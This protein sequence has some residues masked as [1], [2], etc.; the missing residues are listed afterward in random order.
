MKQ[1]SLLLLFHFIAITV[2]AQRPD[3]VQVN[4]QWYFVYPL[5]EKVVPNEAI[6][7]QLDLSE[8]QFKL[9]KEWKLTNDTRLK[10]FKRTMTDSLNR[11]LI[12]TKI[13]VPKEQ[14][15]YEW[16]D[17]TQAPKLSWPILLMRKK[18][19]Y[20]K[21]P[22]LMLDRDLNQ[23]QDLV[24][25]VQNLPNGKYIQYFEPMLSYHNRK[26]SSELPTRIAAMFELKNNLPENEFTRFNYKGDTIRHGF[27]TD[28]LKE[29]EWTLSNR[30][31]QFHSGIHGLNE[32]RTLY[33]YG[34]S[35][36]VELKKGILE[37]PFYERIGGSYK[38]V[39]YFKN[40]YADSIWRIE[41]YYAWRTNEVIDYNSVL[42]SNYKQT[43]SLIMEPSTRIYKKYEGFDFKERRDS[44]NSIPYQNCQED[45]YEQ[46]VPALPVMDFNDLFEKPMRTGLVNLKLADDNRT[47]YQRNTGHVNFHGTK[48]IFE[49]TRLVERYTYVPDLG[50]IVFTRFYK[51]GGVFDTLG[52]EAQSKLFV[53]NIYDANGKLFRTTTYN[54]AGEQVQQ[55]DYFKRKEKKVHYEKPVMIEGFETVLTYNFGKKIRQWDSYLVINGKAY[56]KI[57]WTARSKKRRTE[58]YEDLRDSS[59]HYVVYNRKGD[60]AMEQVSYLKAID[61]S[62][63][64][65]KAIYGRRNI[66]PYKGIKLV[67]ENEYDTD[68]PVI[69]AVADQLYS[70]KMTIQFSDNK[71]KLDDE[72]IDGLEWTVPWD[73]SSRSL[74]KQFVERYAKD[75]YYSSFMHDSYY[76]RDKKFGNPFSH[77]MDKLFQKQFG[78]YLIDRMEGEFQN[79]QPSGNWNY[80][81]KKGE[82]IFTLNF[83]N[84]QPNGDAIVFES[85]DGPNRYDRKYHKDEPYYDFLFSEDAP[86]NYRKETFHFTDGKLDGPKVTYTA[87]GDTLELEE[88]KLGE[89]HGK[90][91]QRSNDNISLEHY[92]NGKLH[93][94]VLEGVLGYNDRKEV[95]MD[96]LNFAHY[97]NGL[98][99]GECYLEFYDYDRENYGN[100]ERIQVSHSGYASELKKVHCQF[101]QGLLQGDYVQQKESGE[102]EFT[103]SLDKGMVNTL[104]FFENGLV[105]YYYDYIES[106]RILPYQFSDSTSLGIKTRFFYG[107]RLEEKFS[108]GLMDEYGNT[109]RLRPY[110]SYSRD[111]YSLLEMYKQGR[112]TKLYPNGKIARRGYRFAD[113]NY[114]D[115][116]FY[117]YDGRRLYSIDYGT[118]TVV[119]HGITYPE[120][121]IKGTY[122]EYDSL[123]NDLCRGFL[124][125]E[126]EKYDCAHSDY[127]AI[128]QF[129]IIEDREDE[130]ER[131]DGPMKYYFDNGML[132]SEGTLK[133]GMPDGVWMFYT[134]DGKLT[135]IGKY[136]NGKKEG[137][138]LKGDLGD[139]KYIGEICLNPDDP[140]LDFHIAELER[141]RDVEI[142]IYK[143]GVAQIQQQYEVTD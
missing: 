121:E 45:R 95:V 102:P 67:Q 50:T 72:P 81:D 33:D 141:L 77:L 105:S 111:D 28:G 126:L 18:H 106:E 136:L 122:V 73:E 75:D 12:R 41:P 118:Q 103:V 140:L 42:D 90:N 70:G 71:L 133:N 88:Y 109:G 96:T 123:G 108:E 55:I 110:R 76:V 54:T 2:V 6:L 128:R 66:V 117:N 10:L 69:L 138:W 119:M 74:H 115:W 57:T 104:T 20:R 91:W 56:T 97:E 62:G 34:S 22:E 100:E 29:R 63:A 25:T 40:G 135:R 58:T 27:F 139:K 51:N 86:K 44:Y 85:Y 107:S 3:S 32:D 116:D 1:R 31:V 16:N 113:T 99:Q 142:V 53:H 52:Y 127:Y 9:F 89:H 79:G 49:G 87:M 101:Q 82:L 98:L 7:D 26:K 61:S 137:R 132:M 15:K 19:W 37:G 24:P 92:Q 78:L 14:N 134:P 64:Y 21:Y 48:Q 59:E 125:E 39:G 23:N 47:G 114:G 46:G 94:L 5:Q 112:F 93:G 120:S 124:I 143:N 65:H 43:L 17:A 30:G 4:G 8:A 83:V 129:I 84:G 11:E 80:Y 36:R 130:Y 13:T 68:S 131:T 60:V 35:I 38:P